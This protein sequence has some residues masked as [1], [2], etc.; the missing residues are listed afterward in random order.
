M[1]N[2]EEKVKRWQ[3]KPINRFYL[4]FVDGKFLGGCV[5]DGATEKEAITNAWRLGINPGGEVLSIRLTRKTVD[6]LPMN[7]L[8]SREEIE[9]FGPVQQYKRT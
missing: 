8:M 4:S 7:R 3:Y 2:I 9:S 6:C 5:V 1:W